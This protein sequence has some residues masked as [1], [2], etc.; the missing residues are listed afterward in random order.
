MSIRVSH[1]HGKSA[2]PQTWDLV[3]AA[4]LTA[5]VSVVLA[6]PFVDVSLGGDHYIHLARHL[7]RGDLT[8]DSV[9]DRYGDVVRL[10]GHTY[11]PFGPL[12]AVLLIPFLPLLER[13]IPLSA[14]S[15]CF[16]LL[17]V[18][19]F[20]RILRNEGVSAEQR[21][22][23]TLLY[24][25]GTS[26]LGIVLVGIS[27]YFAHVVASTFLLLAMLVYGRR[28]SAWKVGLLLGLG[29]AAR[30]TVAFAI[31]YF[32]H[33]SRREE[34]TTDES[35]RG[36]WRRWVTLLAGLAV[37][38][39][40]LAAYNYFRFGN[41]AETGFGQARL[42]EDVLEDARD[43]GLFS[44]I[45]V[46]KNIFFMLLKGPELVGGDSV[47]VLSFP[48]LR[49][50]AWGMGLFFTSPAL[51]Y[52]FRARLG[53][54]RVRSLWLGILA[55]AAPILLYYGIGYVQF[56]YRYALDFMPFLALLAALGMPEPMT[57]RARLLV[58]LSVVICMWGAIHLATWI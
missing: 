35:G 34:E 36:R 26:Y 23:A 5:V 15:Y 32:L 3:F 55:V 9:S 42:Y 54:R 10:G 30:L 39:L 47:P 19:V 4:L 14:V 48:Y 22:W 40:G 56:G 24:F 11:L 2:K 21:R 33:R 41:I 29:A 7:A 12:P 28:T 43:A 45:H 44:L 38:L 8:I 13:G 57:N 1:S 50:S 53:E 49:P 6:W 27:T 31:S 51:L 18:V 52:A 17:N 20:Y 46:P 58:S 37:P 16:T 25:A